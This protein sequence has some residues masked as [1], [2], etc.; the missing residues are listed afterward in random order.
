MSHAQDTAGLL[1]QHAAIQ[2]AN[3]LE[4]FR[5][6]RSEWLAT[7]RGQFVVIGKQTFGGFHPTY[8]EAV[9]AGRRMFGLIAPFLVE[10][11]C[12]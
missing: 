12:D 8:E 11:I 10:E 3:E 4:F 7:H 2:L 5:Q 9:R 6:F 1:R